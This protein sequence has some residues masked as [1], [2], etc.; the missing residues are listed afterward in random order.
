MYQIIF[1]YIVHNEYNYTLFSL[2]LFFPKM[3]L[4]V[5]PKRCPKRTYTIYVFN[6]LLCILNWM[7]THVI[8]QSKICWKPHIYFS[9]EIPFHQKLREYTQKFASK[10]R[11]TSHSSWTSDV[12]SCQSDSLHSTEAHGKSWDLHL[13]KYP[14][15][16]FS[17][18]PPSP[19]CSKN[20]FLKQFCVLLW[21]SSQV[22][23]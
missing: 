5:C 21:I 12:T 2:L 18:P 9:I 17:Y 7:L 16:Q 1:I 3:F 13:Q 22:W 8:L 15:C 6:M 10:H 4:R 23:C 19:F 14:S 20:P 11:K